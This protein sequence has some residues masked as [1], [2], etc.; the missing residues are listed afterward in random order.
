MKILVIGGSGFIGTALVGRLIDLGYETSIFDKNPSGY[1][2]HLVTIG[3]VRD[4]EALNRAIIGLAMLEVCV[5]RPALF[6]LSPF[7]KAL[8]GQS[9][10][11]SSIPGRTMQWSSIRSKGKAELYRVFDIIDCIRRVCLRS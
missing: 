2:N 8:K 9:N 11:N 1:F 6:L 4:K 3:D 10:T 7:R 5:L